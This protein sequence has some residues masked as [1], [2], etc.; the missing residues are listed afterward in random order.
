MLTSALFLREEIDLGWVFLGKPNLE[1]D[2]LLHK[3]HKKCTHQ[4]IDYLDYQV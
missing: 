1:N 4:L 3:K 2:L